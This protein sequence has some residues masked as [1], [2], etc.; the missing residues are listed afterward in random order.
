[1][2]RSLHRLALVAI[3]AAGAL[4]PALSRAQA[5]L[6]QKGTSSYSIDYND[7]SNIHH[8][9]PN[10]DELDAGHT[11]SFTTDFGVSYSPSDRVSLG[12]SLPYVTT[13]Y[14]GNRRHP[15]EVD[16]GDY[17]STLTDLR[18]EAHYQAINGPFAVAPY[19]AYIIPT[20]GYETLGHAA[21]GR[22]L[23]EL[24]IGTF[25][26]KSLDLWLPRTY[27]QARFS[28]AFVEVVAG[29]KHDHINADFEIG[30]FATPRWSLRGMVYWQD[31]DGG[32]PVPIP[33]SNPLYPYHDRLAAV[34]F[35]NVGAGT[36]WS[37]SD[38]M[39]LY[40]L[41]ATAIRGA[42]GHELDR[43]V[44]IGIGYGFGLR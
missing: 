20:H 15:T 13:A 34:R 4:Y 18:I 44:S 35:L 31:T 16:D 6:P 8:F 42:N 30:Y 2:T 36:A 32:I 43:S 11:R 14:H 41:Y 17:H 22:G 25:V 29:V 38:H 27:L 21:P 1:M 23:Q 7:T 26:G 39:S 28:Y 12:A 10:G 3:A 37:L 19:A 9:L 5:W 33:R 40:A 24:V